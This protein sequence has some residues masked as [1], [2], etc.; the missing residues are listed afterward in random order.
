MPRLLTRPRIL[1][2]A[3]LLFL[4]ALAAV[5]QAVLLQSYRELERQAIEQSTEQVFRALEAELR[6]IGLVGNDYASWDEMYGFVRSADPEFVANNFSEPGMRDLELDAVWVMDETGREVFS[7]EQDPEGSR[8]D[9]PAPG[10]AGTSRSFPCI[11]SSAPTA[12]DPP[13]ASS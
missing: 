4:A 6:Q 13:G 7:A 1:L 8:Y 3:A 12:P 11:R 2:L 5:V 9:V 10:W